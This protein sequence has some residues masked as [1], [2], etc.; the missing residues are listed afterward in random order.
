MVS[1]CIQHC[2]HTISGIHAPSCSRCGVRRAH[3]CQSRASTASARQQF[4]GVCVVRPAAEGCTCGDSHMVYICV[5]MWFCTSAWPCLSAAQLHVYEQVLT[6]CVQECVQEVFTGTRA[7]IDFLF[8]WSHVFSFIPESMRLCVLRG[9]RHSITVRRMLSHS[10]A[11]V[12]FH[13][14]SKGSLGRCK[15]AYVLTSYGMYLLFVHGTCTL[16]YCTIKVSI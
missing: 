8:P 9:C 2:W 12:C 6:E 5:C 13:S 4:V 1:A 10:R 14:R 3:L 15:V 7:A 11:R 16:M